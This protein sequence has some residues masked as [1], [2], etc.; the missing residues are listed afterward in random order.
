MR[1]KVWTGNV[2]RRDGENRYCSL[3]FGHFIFGYVVP[4]ALQW[5]NCYYNTVLPK[6]KKVF[7]STEGE[8]EEIEGTKCG[9]R[10]EFDKYNTSITSVRST[11]L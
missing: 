1:K 2:I 11:H 4:Y 5:C 10:V 8:K 3:H 7:L 6:K 9:T